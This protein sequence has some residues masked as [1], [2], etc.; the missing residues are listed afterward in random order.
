MYGFQPQMQ[1]NVNPY[2][3]R[4]NNLQND[5]SPKMEI[6]R[7]NGKNGAEAFAL[8]PNSSVILLDETAPKIW[9]KTTDGAGYPTLTA[10]EIKPY[11]DEQQTITKSLEM[12]V[13]RLEELLNA[14][15]DTGNAKQTGATTDYTAE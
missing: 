7:V 4:L 10:Y 3:A 15:S 9:L 14:K 8:P 5:F 2:Q 1:Y 11:Q 13:S 6:I 12:R